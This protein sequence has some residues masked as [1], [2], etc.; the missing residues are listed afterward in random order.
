MKINLSSSTG[1]KI[2]TKKKTSLNSTHHLF[3]CKTFYSSS[4]K[5]S[6]KF[7]FSFFRT[8]WIVANLGL[9]DE[10]GSRRGHGVIQHVSILVIQWFQFS[11]NYQQSKNCNSLG[12]WMKF[13]ISNN[14]TQIISLPRVLSHN[15]N[16]PT[17]VCEST[18]T[19]VHIF[20]QYIIHCILSTSRHLYDVISY[21]MRHRI[22]EF[23]INNF[24]TR[25]ISF[26]FIEAGAGYAEMERV[27]LF[28]LIS[29][30][31]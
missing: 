9:R 10:F 3:P 2:F 12:Q 1:V 30:L 13:I 18:L 29:R 22:G 21:E 27:R 24:L 11:K 31:V 7:K 8:N 25:P 19:R 17:S 28:Q 6:K 5:N 4:N 26:H 14:I 23:S 16:I 20:I 15:I